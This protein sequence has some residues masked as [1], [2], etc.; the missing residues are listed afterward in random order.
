MNNIDRRHFL[1][2]ALAALAARAVAAQPS[3]PDALALL[4]SMVQ[5]YAKVS[6]CTFELHKEELVK[7]AG[8]DAPSWRLVKE[9][10]QV[11]FRK[12]LRADAGADGTG[13]ARDIRFDKGC[14]LLCPVVFREGVNGD[15]IAIR[16]VINVDPHGAR[17]MEGQHHPITNLDL[18]ATIG[19]IHEQA[20]R[21]QRAGALTASIDG[22]SRVYDRDVYE[23]S[24]RL[25]GAVR[26]VRVLA[27]ETL[28]TFAQ[29][30]GTQVHLLVHHNDRLASATDAVTADTELLVPEYYARRVR[31]WIDIERALPLQIEV[32]DTSERLYERYAYRK[33]ATNVGLTD[34]HFS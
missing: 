25:D 32:Y 10:G 21:A 28:R 6:D 9:V 18:G 33:L 16:G 15:R 3:P 2:A 8:G 1:A 34:E 26:S 23:F 4:A 30:T 19:L 22:R 20:T 5:A 24:A 11:R 7:S 14:A 31:L 27:G 13:Y 29:R 12:R 17:A